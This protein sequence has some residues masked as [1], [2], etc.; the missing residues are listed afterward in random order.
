MHGL[1]SFADPSGPVSWPGFA[2]PNQGTK[3]TSGGWGRMA[4]LTNGTW[5]CV[6]TTFS[7][8]QN[9]YLGIYSSTDGA[10]TWSYVCSVK[11]SG[12]VLDNGELI[13][14]TNGTILLTMRSLIL[15]NS[16]HLPVYQSTNN[17]LTWTYLSNIDSN[18]G[19]NVGGLWEPKFC[20]VQ[21]GLLAAFY[22]SEAHPG[23]SQIISERISTNNGASWGGEIWAVAQSG[24]GNL[25][26]GMPQICQMATSNYILVYEI[27]GIGNADVYYNIS[28]NGIDWPSSLGVHIPCQ[29]AG[30]FVAAL[31]DGRLLVTSSENQISFSEDFGA[32]W[33]KIDPPAW[34]FGFSFDWDAIYL[35]QSN[36]VAVCAATNGLWSTFGTLSPPMT[37]PR[38][39]ASDFS[40]GTD[41]NWTRYGGNFAFAN[42]AYWLNDTNGCG[43]ALTGSEFWSDGVLQSDVML[44]TPGNAGL[45]FHATNPD[46]TGPDGGFDY[47]AGLDTGG[48]IVFGIQSN[49]WTG[50]TNVPLAIKTNTWHHMTVNLQ[51]SNI[52]IYVDS[53]AKPAI[54]YKSGALAR[55]QIGVRAFECN[56]AFM[57]VTFSNA[58]PAAL[59]IRSV[60]NQVE[61]S[62]PQTSHFLKLQNAPSLA[63]PWTA[64]TNVPNL[65]Q[66]MW[67]VFLNKTP[68]GNQSFWRVSE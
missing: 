68:L 33:Q 19:T 26:P 7:R 27:V 60:S 32:T 8:G 37:W 39:Y 62:W 21:N 22:S 54:S 2:S 20:L 63:M 56:A 31:P 47:Y 52:A 10:R 41:S 51:G 64:V 44:S 65:L 1:V 15:S 35:V 25:R 42:G 30:P 59:Q 34:N 40:S 9:S 49:S 14:L 57:N 11:E 28:S 58:A 3:I 43:K 36:Q 61:F 53:A 50:I 38:Q 18:E 55:G 12:R 24:G 48:F 23:Y 46:Y 17:G 5:L 4:R 66:G 6:S 16:Y 67:S 13:A 29:H 45:I